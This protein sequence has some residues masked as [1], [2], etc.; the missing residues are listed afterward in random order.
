MAHTPYPYK[1]FKNK[2]TS[3]FILRVRP[4]FIS[5]KYNCDISKGLS[6]MLLQNGVLYKQEEKFFTFVI[7]PCWNTSHPQ[8]REFLYILFGYLDSWYRTSLRNLPHLLK[9]FASPEWMKVGTLI[10]SYF[11]FTLPRTAET[12]R[13]ST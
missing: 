13:N 5:G 2:F 12:T 3:S 9:F 11:L 6:Q 7:E 4:K 1:V 8:F 10:N